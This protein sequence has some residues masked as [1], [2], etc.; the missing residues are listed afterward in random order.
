MTFDSNDLSE[1]LR[2]L[3]AGTPPVRWLV[4]YSGGIDST[5]LLHALAK[6]EKTEEVLAIHVDHGLHAD[7]G[8]WEQ[9][10]QAFAA[11]LGVDYAAQAVTVATKSQNGPEAAARRARYDAFLGLVRTG[12]CLLS[13]HHEDDQA[14]T[15]LLNLM[16]GSGPA[17]LAGIGIQQSFGR[18]Y[19]LRPLLGIPGDAIQEYA[20]RH[21]LTWIEDPSNAD[22]RF[23]RNFLRNEVV[24][25]LT[26]RWPAVA[27]RLRRSAELVGESSELLNDLAD[28]DLQSLGMPQKLSISGLA[29]LTAPRQRNVLRRAVRLCGLPSPPATRVYQ[30]LNELLPARVDAQPLVEWDGA[31]VR[32]Y[33][34]H[35][36]VMSPLQRVDGDRDAGL[37]WSGSST[38]SLGQGRG[39]LTLSAGVEEGIDPLLAEE[40]LTIRYRDGGETIR[41]GMQGHTKKLKKLLQEEGIVPWMR[42][43]LPLIFSGSKLVAVADLWID[44]D[45]VANPGLQVKWTDR[46]ALK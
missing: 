21:G 46:P 10:C 1:R 24:P 44:A 32:R 23:D 9:H 38:L 27:N 33:R 30:V 45:C 29:E 37:L 39:S 43:A 4:A 6:S 16:R 19:L 25:K 3:T 7:S 12:D 35:L 15:L 36:Y 31:C 14:E 11:S 40:G 26:A 41:L 8:Q 34:D 5:V 18:G 2:A 20:A 13:A 22:S 28:I 17:G 42:G